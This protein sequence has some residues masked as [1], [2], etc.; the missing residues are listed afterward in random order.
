M[1]TKLRRVRKLVRNKINQVNAML[2]ER[3]ILDDKINKFEVSDYTF[4]APYRKA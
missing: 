2:D 4:F 1:R 3:E